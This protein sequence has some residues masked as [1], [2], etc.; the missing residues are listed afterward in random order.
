MSM[1]SWPVAEWEFYQASPDEVRM[2]RHRDGLVLRAKVIDE[3]CDVQ[4]HELLP[5][6]VVNQIRLMLDLV[7]D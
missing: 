1:K 5:V 7:E 3:G 2:Y 4:T 6:Y